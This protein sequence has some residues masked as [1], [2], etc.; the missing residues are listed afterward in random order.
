MFFQGWERLENHKSKKGV[1]NSSL[2]RGVAGGGGGGGAWGARDPPLIGLLFSKQPTIFR[3]QKL[4]GN[5]L[6]VKA[7]VKKPT[8]LKFVFLEKYFRR[9]LLIFS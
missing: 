7:I 8:F 4:H 9:R 3:W 5:I 1:V 2:S 6:A